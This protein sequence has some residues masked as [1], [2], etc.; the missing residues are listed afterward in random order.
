MKDKFTSLSAANIAQEVK[1]GNLSPI[2]VTQAHLNRVHERNDRTNAFITITDELAMDM[3]REAARAVGNDEPLGPL[4]GVPVAIK[5]LDDVEGVPTTAGSRL[6]ENRIASHDSP[7]VER[8]KDAGAVILGKTNT[9]EL[10]LGTT[11]DNL[12][13]GP[14]ATPFDPQL[15][16]GGS[17]GGSGAALGDSLVPLATGSD[18]GGSIRIPAS[19]CGVYGL[20]PTYGLIPNVKRPNSFATHTPFAHEGPM[21]RT[22]EDA[23]IFLDVVSG[24]HPRDPF[25]V[26]TQNEYSAVIGQS[27]DDMKI[28]YS[29]DLGTYPVAS[30]IRDVLDT[31]VAVFERA[32]AAVDRVDPDL[33]HSQ[34]EIMNA[35][36]TM[37]NV[38]WQSLFDNLESQGFDP[39]GKDR[40]RIRPY[41]VNLIMNTESLSAKEYK[42][43]DTVRTRIFDGIQDIFEEYD[44]LVSATLGTTAFPHDEEPK[45]IDGES[46][47]PLRGWVLTQPYN[48]TGHPAASIP[49]GFVDDL[50][51]G[52]QLCGQRFAD[53]DVLRASA[54]FEE[55]QPWHSQ[56][57]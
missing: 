54:V 36:Y 56:Y 12:I 35:Y 52:M 48:F 27:I 11:T 45:K 31:A 33:G 38:R 55:S 49:A 40:D 19:L 57:P 10:G 1:S 7:V 44:L 22:V 50:P 13:T 9:P 42:E 6:F 51:V 15:V 39:R 53:D 17:S 32:G 4:H 25:S 29:P 23:A 21:T 43:A 26:P 41:L 16:S 3:A 34:G 37:V 2:D 5:D 20:K 47:E 46:I 8:L 18:V 14:T 30:T 24:F 28:A